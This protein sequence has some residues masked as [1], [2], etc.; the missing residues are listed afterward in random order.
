MPVKAPIV[1]DIVLIGGG[2]SHVGVLMRF[3]MQPEPGVRLTVICRD[4]DTPYSGMLPGYVAG[5]YTFD[6]VHIDLRRLC[7]FA[8]ARFYRDQ[9][10]DIDRR[11]RR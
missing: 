8:G 9:V 4:T 5:H 11:E 10:I 1:R 3:A 6:D 7:Q 2:H